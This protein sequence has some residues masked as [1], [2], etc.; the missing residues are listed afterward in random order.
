MTS[1][2]SSR[3]IGFLL[4]HF[5]VLTGMV[6]H[7]VYRSKPGACEEERLMD[8][9]LSMDRQVTMKIK[10]NIPSILLIEGKKIN[11]RYEGQ[12]RSCPRCLNRLH[13]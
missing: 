12:A 4:E 13:I 5:G 1:D 3:A 10:R 2:T 11:I 9:V 8:G 6:E 7:Q